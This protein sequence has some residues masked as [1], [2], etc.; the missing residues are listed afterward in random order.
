M[1]LAEILAAIRQE[2]EEEIERINSAAA[3]E[4]ATIEAEADAAAMAAQDEAAHARDHA[5]NA[6]ADRIRNRAQLAA[7]RRLREAEEQLYQAAL[8]RVRARLADVV[9]TDRYPPVLGRLLAESR[10]VLPDATTFR[11]APP[12]AD[13]AESLVAA[14]R[15]PD[16][17]VEATL[18]DGRGVELATN[19]GRLVR[20]TLEGRVARAE[21]HLRR[22]LAQKVPEIGMTK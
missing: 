17:I 6:S 9:A 5:A 18:P 3:D 7:N 1:A 12:D 14:G 16:C 15:F 19:D 8:D 13:L 11:V 10:E 21:P 4:I 2:T 22:L 20:N